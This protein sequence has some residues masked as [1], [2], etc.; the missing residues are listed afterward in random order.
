MTHDKSSWTLYVIDD[1]GSQHVP[2]QWYWFDIFALSSWSGISLLIFLLVEDPL[3]LMFLKSR[4][5]LISYTS[6]S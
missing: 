2:S 1:S 3:M 6:G 5:F 4:L